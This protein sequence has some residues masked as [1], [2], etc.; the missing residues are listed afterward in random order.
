DS[1][2]ALAQLH[3]DYDERRDYW[4]K[5]DLPGALIE[6]LTKKS[7]QQVQRF[8]NS[9]EREL[10]PAL[11]KGDQAAAARAYADASKAYTAHR[12]VI[13]EVVADANDLNAAIESE[14][15]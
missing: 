4:G 9:V 6:K 8:W 1:K 10:L 5:S 11:E 14:A 2:A 13:D 3:K 7:D 12:T 15:K